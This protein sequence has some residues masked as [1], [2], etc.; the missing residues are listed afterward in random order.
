[1]TEADYIQLLKF[2]DE[3]GI[4]EIYN[5]IP[6]NFLES[7][8]ENKILQNIQT[9]KTNLS[10]KNIKEQAEHLLESVNN[11]SE[12]IDVIKNFKLHPLVKF[13]SNIITGIG[14]ENPELLVITEY[15]NEQEDTSGIF[16]TGNTGELLNKILIAI[17]A[18]I[19]TNTFVFPLSPYRAPGSRTLTDEE[20]SVLEPFTKKYIS[21]LKPKTIIIFG[22]LGVKVL[23]KN[24]SSIT[25]LR[26][27]FYN[28][29]DTDIKILPTFS[30][31]YLLNNKEAKKKTWED[32]QLL[33]TK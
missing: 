31:N 7:C 15:P 9:N 17:N 24:D 32:L 2:Y 19:E 16:L 12:L 28:Y 14:V 29:L 18:S 21:I 3:S 11:I 26:G 25:S 20:L 13:V 33:K 1:M 6:F 22:I 5:D 4:D 23:L 10:I 30:L 27:K 8:K